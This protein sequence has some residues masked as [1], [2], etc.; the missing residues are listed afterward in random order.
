MQR[1]INTAYDFIE[2][3]VL[4]LLPQ[5]DSKRVLCLNIEQELDRLLRIEI[6]YEESDHSL[7]Q[8]GVNRDCESDHFSLADT[9]EYCINETKVSPKLNSI[10]LK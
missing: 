4:H 6:N 3:S 1:I 8:Y 9:L 7:L 10:D 2:S 5:I